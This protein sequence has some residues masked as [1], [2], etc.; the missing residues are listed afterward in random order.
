MPIFEHASLPSI[1]NSSFASE[2]IPGDQITRIRPSLQSFAHR[3]RQH[4]HHAG[5]W[6]TSST[7][8]AAIEAN[9]PSTKGE[10]AFDPF[11]TRAMPCFLA[12]PQDAFTSGVYD[13]AQCQM[14]IDES[15]PLS[16]PGRL[17]HLLLPPLA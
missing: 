15:A 4:P 8:G 12:C 7:E 14:T 10:P 16:L 11:P 6:P 17:Q 3:K 9:L 1:P 5:A 13:R 2:P